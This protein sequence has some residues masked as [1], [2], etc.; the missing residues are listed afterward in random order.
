MYKDLD[1]NEIVKRISFPFALKVSNI[2]D[3]GDDDTIRISVL[4]AELEFSNSELIGFLKL[5][6]SKWDGSDY[7]HIFFKETE[8]KESLIGKMNDRLRLHCFR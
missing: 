5:I 4:A 3:F 8:N 6:V 1:D 7:N 2:Y